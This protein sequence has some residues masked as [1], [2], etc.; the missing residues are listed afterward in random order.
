MLLYYF[1]IS[2]EHYAHC[3]DRHGKASRFKSSDINKMLLSI[4]DGLGSSPEIGCKT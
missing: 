4:S 3:A 2:I 1:L